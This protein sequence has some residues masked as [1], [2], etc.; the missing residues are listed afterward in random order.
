MSRKRQFVKPVGGQRIPG[1]SKQAE[2]LRTEPKL[3]TLHRHRK[4]SEELI[5]SV[6]CSAP[7][8]QQNR[9][10][11]Q[12]ATLHS[13]I[14]SSV[15]ALAIS[16]TCRASAAQ[17]HARCAPGALTAALHDTLCTGRCGHAHLLHVCVRQ[18]L[19]GILQVLLGVLRDSHSPKHSAKQIGSQCQPSACSQVGWTHVRTLRPR[20]ALPY[21][22]SASCSDTFACTIHP[23]RVHS[24]RDAGRP[25]V[26]SSAPWRTRPCR[27]S[28]SHPCARCAAPP[29][30]P[31]H[32]WPPSWPDPCGAPAGATH[33][34]RQVPAAG[35]G[36]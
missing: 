29:W 30:T 11:D 22:L 8:A 14:T 16:S 13:F 15:L 20:R 9:L 24:T 36:S 19:D 32:T 31:R 34:G 2:L 35:E 27:S 18:L 10:L 4:C 7:N 17:Q 21:T 5:S 33:Q 23:R 25:C 6:L 12:N 3:A 1:S 26:S 28:S